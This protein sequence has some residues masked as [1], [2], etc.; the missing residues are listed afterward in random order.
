[1]VRSVKKA[2]GMVL[3]S[4]GASIILLS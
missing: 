2:I 4:F 3:I 1:V